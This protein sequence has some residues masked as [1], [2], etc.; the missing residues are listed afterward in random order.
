MVNEMLE[1]KNVDKKFGKHQVLKDCSLNIQ[2]GTIFG[3]VGINGA[4]KSTLLRMI[5]GIVQCDNGKI[6]FDNQNTF[7]NAKVRKEILYLS[8][9]SY[10]ERSATINSLKMLYQTFYQF[11]EERFM[12]YLTIFNLEPNVPLINFSKGMKRQAFILFALAIKPKLLLLDE[13]FDGL[14]P[15]IRLKIKKA[16]FEFLD[17]EDVTII[18]A[19][20]NLKELEDICDS[21]G[22][23]ENGH[24]RQA[25]DLQISKE[26]VNK[27]QLAFNHEIDEKMFKPFN[28]LHVSKIGSV[29][30][31][32]IR[33]NAEEVKYKL[34]QFNPLFIDVLNV[35]FEELF[36]YEL[37]NHGEL[38]E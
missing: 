38:Y 8:D 28:P 17:E 4:G 9:D 36:I 34:E 20:H 1:I 11:D 33:G 12:K 10:F 29:I 27:Y 23:L 16:L 6:C 26:M 22:I 13:A 37:E 15:I 19:S 30:T 3:L 5:A 25:G 21:F 32:V 2:S 31:L 7:T 14:D 35:N 24:I 18:I